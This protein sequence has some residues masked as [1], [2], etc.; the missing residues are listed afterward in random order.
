LPDHPWLDRVVRGRT[1]IA[2]L[3]VMLVGIVAMQVEAL[4]LGAS[5][6]RSLQRGSSLQS[7]N[8][9]LRATVAGLEDDQRIER[10]AAA[11]GMVMPAP[12]GVGFVS[13][14][15]A[16]VRKAIANIHQPNT[17]SFN[18]LLSSNGSVAGIAN[19]A[20]TAAGAPA[21][22]TGPALASATTTPASPA[23]STTASTVPAQTTQPTTT[24]T[25]TAPTQ[26]VA[27]PPTVPVQTTSSSGSSAVGAAGTAPSTPTQSSS[28]TSS[29]GGAGVPTGG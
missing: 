14:G 16:T 10:L 9:Q 19:P 11:M 2:L 15:P 5:I 4:K 26:A 18:T 13:V 17:A 25:P 12:D 23:A 8:E 7:R 3:G 21:A 6:G 1:W 29:T 24:V 22:A 20:A 27:T 28:A